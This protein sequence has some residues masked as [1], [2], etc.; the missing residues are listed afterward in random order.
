MLTNTTITNWLKR[1]GND[2][3][4]QPTRTAQDGSWRAMA[5]PK[6]KRLKI[7]DRS[8]VSTMQAKVLCDPG[9]GVADHIT[10][11]GSTWEIVQVADLDHH[12]LDHTT[13]L[14]VEAG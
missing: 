14:L 6:T 9:L 11:Q 7:G 10:L 2:R 5:T 12:T 8:I 13:V 3:Y 4:G 1:T